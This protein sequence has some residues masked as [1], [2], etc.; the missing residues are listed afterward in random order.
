M[1]PGKRPSQKRPASGAAKKRAPPP[2]D[3]LAQA[4]WAEADSALAEALIECDRAIR[5][6]DE[7]TRGEALALLQLALGRAA[8][9]RGLTRTGKIGGLEDFDPA[10]HECA[11][12]AKRAPK[13]VRIAEPG[14][15]RG[16]EV[17]I[18]ARVKPA[19]AKRI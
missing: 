3:A 2:V 19:R 10:R 11:A 18:K 9:R 15:A 16:R 7:G 8:R 14:V 12:P 5:A 17:L 13:R 1:P 4:A 6:D